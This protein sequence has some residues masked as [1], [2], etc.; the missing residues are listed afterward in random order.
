MDNLS[1]DIDAISRLAAYIGRVKAEATHGEL[2]IPDFSVWQFE[3]S[4]EA[5]L[6]S[7]VSECYKWWRETWVDDIEFLGDQAT[8]NNTATVRNFTRVIR[9]LRTAHQHAGNEEAKKFYSEWL[10]TA[11]GFSRPATPPR[12]AACGLALSAALGQA[13][14]ALASLADIA[15]QDDNLTRL[16]RTR[17]EARRIADPIAAR[18]R[19]ARDLGLSIPRNSIG[20]LD[21]QINFEW[22]RRIRTAQDDAETLL[23][24]VIERSL[25]GWSIS[26]LPCG[27][28]E[29][30][31]RLSCW[32]SSDRVAAL[33]LAHAVADIASYE[34]TVQFLDRVAEL[35]DLLLAQD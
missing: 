10:H 1:A 29:V 4:S 8:G 23:D 14:V 25:V 2:P 16:W 5:D 26:P 33:T 34:T 24:S 20:H 9:L 21:R 3:V 7:L 32:S 35:W 22:R 30:L 13:L 31:D 19:V 27:Y 28:S 12:W 17:T 18:A 6:A 15:S 11:S